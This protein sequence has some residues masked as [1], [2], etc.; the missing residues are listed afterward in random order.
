MFFV[1][2]FVFF[3]GLITREGWIVQRV[4]LTC[5]HEL[6]QNTNWQLLERVPEVLIF[7]EFR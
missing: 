4:Y 5:T 2:N 1:F 6:Q 3:L 7:D